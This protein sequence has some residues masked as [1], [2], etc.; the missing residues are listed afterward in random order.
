M[1][2]T[3][4]IKKNQFRVT[5]KIPIEIYQE[6]SWISVD[7]NNGVDIKCQV[8]FGNSIGGYNAICF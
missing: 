3:I 1:S 5:V 7:V 4:Q 6:F 2:I 8:Y